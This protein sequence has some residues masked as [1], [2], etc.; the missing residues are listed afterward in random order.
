MKQMNKGKRGRKDR[1]EDGFIDEGGVGEDGE[2][3]PPKR[4]KKKKAVDPDDEGEAMAS[5]NE[6]RSP[7]RSRSVSKV[8]S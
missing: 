1:A 6:S 4:S 8:S 5:G 3:R 2:P 7:S